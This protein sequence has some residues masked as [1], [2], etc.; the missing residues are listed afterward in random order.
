MLSLTS[1]PIFFYVETPILSCRRFDIAP[2]GLGVVFIKSLLYDM[3]M[4]LISA[5][6]N[7]FLHVFWKA[8][9]VFHCFDFFACLYSLDLRRTILFRSLLYHGSDFLLLQTL[10]RMFLSIDFPIPDLKEFHKSSTV[11]EGGAL[12]ISLESWSM[13]SKNRGIYLSY[14]LVSLWSRQSRSQWHNGKMKCRQ[15]LDFKDQVHIFAEI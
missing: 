7:S 3:L 11:E 13:S 15:V 5:F 6:L 10:V 12:V 1:W 2:K 4:W 9:K 14:S 8:L